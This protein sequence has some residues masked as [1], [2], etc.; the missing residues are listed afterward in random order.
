MDIQ[1]QHY[2]WLHF[3]LPGF[4]DMYLSLG[5]LEFFARGVFIKVLSFPAVGIFC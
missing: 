3:R 5:V 2:L 4:L 1:E